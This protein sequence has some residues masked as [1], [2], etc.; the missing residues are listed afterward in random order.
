MPAGH[1]CGWELGQEELAGVERSSGGHYRRLPRL[2]GACCD[3]RQGLL[4][5][6]AALED[7][8]V[9]DHELKSTASSEKELR[10]SPL[11]PLPH[12]EIAF[13]VD[14]RLERSLS[15]EEGLMFM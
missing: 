2:I 10:T 15:S 11:R 8:T 13:R 7:G 5:L 12:P 9:A 3:A 1:L 6:R 4:V 14:H